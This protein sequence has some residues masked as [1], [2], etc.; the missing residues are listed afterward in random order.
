MVNVG[1]IYTAFKTGRMIFA[2]F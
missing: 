1:H 2:L